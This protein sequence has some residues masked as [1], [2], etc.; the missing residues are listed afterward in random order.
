MKA[1]FKIRRP[2]VLEVEWEVVSNGIA[3]G[4]I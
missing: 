4:D 1:A 3:A 2:L